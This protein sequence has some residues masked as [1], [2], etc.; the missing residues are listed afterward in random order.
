MSSFTDKL[1]LMSDDTIKILNDDY[2]L[3]R[4]NSSNKL[5]NSGGSWRLCHRDGVEDT[6]YTILG[7]HKKSCFTVL[8]N[9]RTRGLYTVVTKDKV[10]RDIDSLAVMNILMDNID[11]DRLCNEWYSN[12]YHL[13]FEFYKYPWSGPLIDIR[14]HNDFTI[15]SFNLDYLAEFNIIYNKNGKRIV[16]FTQG[17]SRNIKTLGDRLLIGILLGR[18]KISKMMAYYMYDNTLYNKLKDNWEFTK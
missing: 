5:F 11:I 17:I 8:G 10:I 16:D 12:N 4:S 7:H 3:T 1:K 9:E 6:E 13:D 15:A 2:Y 14:C 18:S